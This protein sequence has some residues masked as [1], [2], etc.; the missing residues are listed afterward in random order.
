M[1]AKN[2]TEGISAVSLVIWPPGVAPP[3]ACIPVCST[4]HSGAEIGPEGKTRAWS[5]EIWSY[6]QDQ[7]DPGNPV[8]VMFVQT[9][10]G[11]TF[12]EGSMTLT[13]ISPTTTFF[14][15]RPERLAGHLPTARFLK[16]WD[17]GKDSFKNDPPNAN[18]SILGDKEGATN[19]V[20]ELSN[21]KIDGENMIYDI[22]ILEGT[23]PES[24][25]V[26]SLF[27]DWWVAGPYFYGPRP[28]FSFQ[29][30]FRP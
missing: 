14:S 23:P 19:I 28:G 29:A 30:L 6:A 17:D 11:V 27:I 20:L 12:S 4:N 9:A 13:G 25:G 7:P 1:L 26:S 10:K 15:D 18:L 16:I 5:I 24:G 2:A 8:S 22:R 3:S 21:P